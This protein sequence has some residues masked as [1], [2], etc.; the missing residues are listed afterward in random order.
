MWSGRWSAHWEADHGPGW[1]EGPRRVSA[2]E[3]ITWG[4]AQAEVVLIRPGD[5][6]VNHSAGRRR[7]ES[8]AGEEFPVWP[9]GQEL[10]RRRD[11]GQEYLDRPDGSPPITWI[12][13]H[14]FVLAIPELPRFVEHYARSLQQDNDIAAVIRPPRIESTGNVD[15][16]FTVRAPTVPAARRAA[17]NATTRAWK[18]AWESLSKPAEITWTRVLTDPVPIDSPD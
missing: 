15:G 16:S 18:A 10:P 7:P 4:R 6:T 2:R 1:R 5:S 9:E 11:A 14:S 12:I 13:E 17:F 8:E 3:A